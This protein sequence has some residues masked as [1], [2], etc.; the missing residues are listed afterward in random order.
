VEIHGR[1]LD[2][3]GKPA[4]GVHVY[5]PSLEEKQKKIHAT[6]TAA[7]GRFALRLPRSQLLVPETKA[8]RH[9]VTVVATAKGWGPAWREVPL[10]NVPKE[11]ALRL[12]KDD[13]PIQ[14]RVLSLE[15][16]PL[17]GV[18]VNV[19]SI[20]AFPK[21]EFSRVLE[22]WRKGN[23][24][25]E[26]P[27]MQTLWLPV[28]DPQHTTTTDADGR[29]HLEGIGRDRLAT[30]YLT[31]PRIQYSSFR[32]M[33]RTGSAVH[34]E[35]GDVTIRPATFE[36]PARP[37]RLIRGTV[38]DEATGKP[39]AGVRV[40]GFDST[41][42]ARTDAQGFFELPGCPKDKTYGIQAYPP[43]DL[44]YFAGSIQIQD[45]EGLGPLT[46]DLE[47]V[48]GIVV[49][50]KIIERESGK[51][52]EGHISYYPLA[53]NPNVMRKRGQ[54]GAGVA[55]ALGP[56]SEAS[57][58]ADGSFR[59]LVLPGP[60]CLALQAKKAQRYHYQ[61]ACVDPATIKAYGGNKDTLLIP[62]QGNSVVGT[63][64]EQFQAIE[65]LNPAKDTRRIETT[66]RVERAPEIKGTLRDP[67][68]KPLGGVNVRG[69]ET[70]Y[71]RTTLATEQFAIHGVNP[72]RP[73]RLAFVHEGRRLIASLEVKGTETKPLT[74]QLE[75]WVT[76]RGRLV[77]A[78]GQPLRNATLYASPALLEEVRTDSEGRFR[79]E[80]LLPD[81]RY[82]LSYGKDKPRRDGTVVKGFVGK[83]GEVRDLGEVRSQPVRME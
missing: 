37:S 31:G 21:V 29:F 3:D 10:D 42:E 82:D 24:Y 72:E 49:E 79:V 22:A 8:L 19:H 9:A 64:Q 5:V 23:P 80:R 4:A 63:P 45:T 14:G 60:G 77:D 76:L 25:G 34:H 26:L 73:R 32:V 28:A 61:T 59:C 75:P 78:E 11:L 41:A 15:G 54:V 53:P 1:V 47:L 30:L 27:D 66:I 39:L 71:S 74:V 12:V 55:S 35:N 68:G 83:A 50:G 43:R 70:S 20:A 6:T 33:T 51:P 18:T 16:K 46:A 48:S 17:A 36:Y 67:D 81:V 58:S 40:S 62:F 7:D 56:H 38:R 65:L 44:P 13:V 2:P 69:L 52:V 57:V